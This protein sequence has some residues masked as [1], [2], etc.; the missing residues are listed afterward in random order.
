MQACFSYSHLQNGWQ[1]HDHALSKF[2]TSPTFA[3]NLH[4]YIYPRGL[5]RTLDSLHRVLPCFS[6]QLCLLLNN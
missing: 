2:L 4:F 6:K 5:T 1:S 3:S